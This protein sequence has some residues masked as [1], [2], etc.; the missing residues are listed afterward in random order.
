M[1]D[2]PTRGSGR[3]RKIGLSCNSNIQVLFTCIDNIHVSVRCDFTV[4]NRHPMKK[5]IPPVYSCLRVQLIHAD[6]A[7]TRCGLAFLFVT[8]Q[9]YRLTMLSFPL[10]AG[11]VL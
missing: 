8:C 1:V 6:A 10:R 5:I 9:S 4:N 11:P 2:G 7:S 3:V